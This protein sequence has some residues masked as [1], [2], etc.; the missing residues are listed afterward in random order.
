VGVASTKFVAKL[1]SARC[2]PDGLMVVPVAGVLD[3]LHPLPVTV[4]W[5]VGARTAEPLH[6]LG[7][8]TVGDLAATPLDTLRRALGVAAADHL[9]ALARGV[10]PRTVQ[11]NEVEKS[12]SSDHTLD[13]DLT[14]EADVLREVL[15]LADD[16][17]RRLRSRG[18]LARTVGIKIRFADFRTVTRVR[19]LANWTDGTAEIGAAASELYRGLDLDR[20]RVRLVGVK[21]ENLRA[22]ADAHEQLTL[23]LASTA[24]T[25]DPH[26]ST[27]VHRAL[28]TD[29]ERA[30][31]T[32]AERA[33]GTDAERAIGT[34]AERAIGTDAERAI[35]TDAE[36]AAGR[37]VDTA[38]DRAVARFGAGAVRPAALV[39]ATRQDGRSG[40][41]QR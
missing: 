30:I 34:D 15:A 31:G 11:P 12:I 35:G 20:P 38:V 19:T 28:G 2:K 10:D 14:D 33:I 32:D 17:A 4:L 27:T 7:I 37:A 18:M 16:V 41:S 26:A 24:R 5:G 29:A 23:D 13:V 25:A 6:R 39:R 9:S 8:R 21:A 40:T 1:A 22:A 36:R 3:F